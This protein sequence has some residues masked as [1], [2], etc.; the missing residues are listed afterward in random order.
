MSI[1]GDALRSTNPVLL[2]ILE[3]QTDTPTY[4]CGDLSDFVLGGVTYRPFGTLGAVGEVSRSSR[5]EV[6]EW[7]IG[8][9]VHK[10][11]NEEAYPAFQQAV[12]D[13]IKNTDVAGKAVIYSWVI[14]DPDTG[15][16]I[17]VRQKMRGFA[18]HMKSDIGPGQ[19][20]LIL[21]CEP[22]IGG[23]IG[24][25]ASFLTGA[26]QQLRYPGDKGLE[27]A[28]RQAGSMVITWRPNV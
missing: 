17:D 1:A 26:D 3:L 2:P 24:P 27:F 7:T 18:S 19:T 13:T 14:L 15:A 11:G 23:A 28:S 8:V 12:R 4:A 20:T 25:R 21:Q 16:V 22:A 6:N 9:M 5:V 10:A